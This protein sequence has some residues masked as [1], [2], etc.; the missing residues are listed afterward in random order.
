MLVYWNYAFPS[1][2]ADRC[3]KVQNKIPKL[4]RPLRIN[5]F[6]YTLIWNNFFL[7]SLQTN[8]SDLLKYMLVLIP[9]KLLCDGSRY[10]ITSFILYLKKTINCAIKNTFNRRHI[11]LPGVL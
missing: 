3:C 8:D 5:N 1:R 6:Y 2:F 11:G 4:D 9:G 10:W 7:L